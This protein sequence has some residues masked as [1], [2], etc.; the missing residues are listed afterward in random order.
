MNNGVKAGAA[1]FSEE[2]ISTVEKTGE[3]RHRVSNPEPW[4][5]DEISS[6]DQ[7]RT[8]KCDRQ[9]LPK[10]RCQALLQNE[11]G[12]QSDPEWCRVA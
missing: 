4:V 3:D 12:S 9:A 7:R 8:Q 11:P 1:S 10:T 5:K 6:H 2:K